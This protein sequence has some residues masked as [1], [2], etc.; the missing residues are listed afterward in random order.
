MPKDDAPADWLRPDWPAHP[1]VHA[2]CTTR[3]GGVSVGPYA[4]LNLGD[5]VGDD[6][7]A[8]AENRRRLQAAIGA[9]PMYLRQMHGLTLHDPDPASP[10]D[11][12]RDRDGDEGED[13][14]RIEADACSTRQ[15][16]VAC[17][18]QAAD[19]L[20]VLLAAAD[21]S[22]VA[23]AH[24]GWRGLAAGVLDAA[25]KPF[26]AEKP[27]SRA[28]PAMKSIAWL[29]PCIGPR[30]FEVGPDVKAAFEQV[31][32]ASNA[33]F[34]PIAASDRG[35]PKWLADLPALARQRLASLGIEEVFGND[36][37]DAWCTVA[38]PSRFFSYRRERIGGRLA[39]CIWLDDR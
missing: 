34:K 9:R 3:A 17:L 14:E 24:A 13:G 35:S 8:V 38:N 32:P 1:R 5:G 39:A 25:F 33:C 21:G 15:A 31:D 37:S 19:C 29:G 11:R 12:D 4:S 22:R 10:R 30:A 27:A 20:P 26:V 2:I 7:R 18:V 6:P 16:G 28:L 23:A 36:S